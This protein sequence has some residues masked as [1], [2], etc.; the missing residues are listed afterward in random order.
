MKKMY[1]MNNNMV[2]F[3]GETN[4]IKRVYTS[5]YK[6]YMKGKLDMY[7]SY[8]MDEN[9]NPAKYKFSDRKSHYM[10]MVDED[11]IVTVHDSD[12]FTGLL[13]DGYVKI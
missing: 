5:I 4:E 10:L 6:A 3:V 7:P 1:D 9:G 8:F 12:T 11:G 13:L 2:G